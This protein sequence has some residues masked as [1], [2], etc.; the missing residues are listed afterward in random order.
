[1]EFAAEFSKICSRNGSMTDLTKIGMSK[2]GTTNPTEISSRRDHI[3]DSA[4][5]GGKDDHT[6]NSHARRTK[7]CQD[8]DQAQKHATGYHSGVTR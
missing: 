3:A 2:D 1:M 7:L 8:R 4:E 6:M 5:I